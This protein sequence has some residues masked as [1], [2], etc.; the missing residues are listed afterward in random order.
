[1]GLS[2]AWE[3]TANQTVRRATLPHGSPPVV[4]PEE[5]SPAVT[6]AASSGARIATESFTT[7][8]PTTESPNLSTGGRPRTT[9]EGEAI[10]LGHPV[11]L[12]TRFGASLL[13]GVV[14]TAVFFAVYLVLGALMLVAGMVNS[15]VVSAIV[16]LLGALLYIALVVGL[17]AYPVLSIGRLGQTIGK[18]TLGVHVVDLRTG[19]PIGA[20]RSFARY[21]CLGLMGA[22]CYLGYLTI[23]LDKSGW[24]RGWHDTM[25]SSVVVRTEPVPF[26]RSLRDVLRAMT[27]R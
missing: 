25:V 24:H 27:R 13:D 10:P 26:G 11:D 14:M 8:S 15:S 7:E 20:G 6:S 12:G 9:P 18:R 4:V 21:L 16:S 3:P 19:E 2:P 1:M 22:P 17:V 5:G 23:L